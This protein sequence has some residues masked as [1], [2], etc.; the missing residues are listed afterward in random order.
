MVEVVYLKIEQM[1]KGKEIQ[2]ITG[3][4][5]KAADCAVWLASPNIENIDRIGDAQGSEKQKDILNTVKIS[6]LFTEECAPKRIDIRRKCIEKKE[7]FIYENPLKFNAFTIPIFDNDSELIGFLEGDLGKKQNLDEEYENFI[8]E[9]ASNYGFAANIVLNTIKEQKLQKE[10]SLKALLSL[11]QESLK[12]YI[13]AFSTSEEF[14]N[15]LYNIGSGIRRIAKN[16]QVLGINAAIEAARLGEEGAGF[17]VVAGEIKK[18]GDYVFSQVDE[19]EKLI[20][21][22]KKQA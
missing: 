15:K 21:T 22:Y 7:T 10:D 6:R 8:R 9:K 14:Y 18:V 5:A 11:A 13:S 2:N 16:I 19:L 17:A 1:Q 4:L 20:R 12:L 3:I